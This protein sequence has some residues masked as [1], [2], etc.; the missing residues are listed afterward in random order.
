LGTVLAK[1]NPEVAF[2]DQDSKGYTL[3]TLTQD[4]ATAEYV[5]L[6]TV[7]AKQF[8]RKVASTWVKSSRTRAALRRVLA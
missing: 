7:I 1:V 6:S 4:T 3:L 5:T 8:T 2:C